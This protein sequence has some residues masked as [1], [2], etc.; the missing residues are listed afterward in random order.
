MVAEVLGDEPRVPVQVVTVDGPAEAALVKQAEG[1]ALLVVGSRSRS[2]LPG[3]V[4][5]SVA[6]HCA[7]NAPCPVMVVHPQRETARSSAAPEMAVSG[8]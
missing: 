2:Q 8:S 6:L 3:M 5:G 7:V 4:L 1:A